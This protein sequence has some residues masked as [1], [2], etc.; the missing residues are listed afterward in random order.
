L[1]PDIGSLPETSA[2]FDSVPELVL[3]LWI[4]IGDISCDR[5]K[6][7]VDTV[8][9]EIVP[10]KEEGGPQSLSHFE[11]LRNCTGN[12]RFAIACHAGQQDD[13]WALFPFGAD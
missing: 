8:T 7:V 9:I 6:D 4:R 10:V 11:P 12:G 1:L 13:A 3:E 5:C 2:V